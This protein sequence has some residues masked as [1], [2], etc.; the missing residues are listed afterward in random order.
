[1]SE[2]KQLLNE[3]KII[4]PLWIV[5]LFVS[6]TE[7]VLGVAVTQTQGGIQIA[8]TVFVLAFPILIAGMFFLILWY[9][10]Y[11][12]YPPTE[13]GNQTNVLDYV[14]AMQGQLVL[15]NQMQNIQE[16]VHNTLTSDKV[17]SELTEVIS[18]KGDEKVAQKIEEILKSVSSSAVNKIDKI[19]SITIS[20]TILLKEKGTV[21]RELYD[22]NE[23]VNTFV[24]L[25]YF[26]MRPEIPP[27][28][29]GS[30]WLLKDKE[31]GKL[32]T[33]FGGKD[34]VNR[35]LS[36]A[37]LYAGMTLLVVDPKKEKLNVS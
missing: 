5:A 10:P 22:P 1:M 3:R 35:L 12:F 32:F 16:V 29:Y 30:R 31:T 13:F 14:R 17:I 20:S 11:V 28:S 8:L 26:K 27:F 33:D 18:S 9:K 36:E 7:V 24:D 4:T 34:S 15:D 37:G 23:Q 2:I 25:L 19:G 21:W 6:L